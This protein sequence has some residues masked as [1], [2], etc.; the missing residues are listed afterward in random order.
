M[1][2]GGNGVLI[3]PDHLLPMRKGGVMIPGPPGSVP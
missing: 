3:L 2:A 1:D